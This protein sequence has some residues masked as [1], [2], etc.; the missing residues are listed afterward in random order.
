MT[1]Y[2]QLYFS[3]ALLAL[4]ALACKNNTSASADTPATYP[5]A[6]TDSLAGFKGCERA[7][8]KALTPQSHEF[9]YQN[10]TFLMTKR[11]DGGEGEVI[12]ITIDSSGTKFKLP[13]VEANFFQGASRDH[14]FVTIGSDP[15]VR[16]VIV[17]S[18]AKNTLTL[19]YRNA[20]LVNDPP[21]VANGSFQFFCPIEESELTK[22]PICPDKE[23]WVKDGKRIG[24]GQR[25]MYHM[26]NRGLTR[27]SE[28][29][30]A[31]LSK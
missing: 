26:Q 1:K 24:Y 28:F 7:G 9:K 4:A 6:R 12:E 2:L 25:Y 20:Y 31:P 3:I 21:F 13:A 23:A 5:G 22:T 30:C 29:T 14:F 17:Y 19:V 18:L 10:Y 8:F 11:E 27:K 16:D 15:E